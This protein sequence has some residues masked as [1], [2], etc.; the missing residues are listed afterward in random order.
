MAFVPQKS[1]S[2]NAFDML[3]KWLSETP[4]PAYFRQI[5][6]VANEYM[7]VC[8]VATSK[9][10]GAVMKIA[11]RMYLTS[12]VYHE[13][14]SMDT[15][16][17]EHR[18]QDRALQHID[19]LDDMDPVVTRVRHLV[20]MYQVEVEVLARLLNRHP[21]LR[22]EAAALRDAAEATFVEDVDT[23]SDEDEG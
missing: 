5:E 12:S 1:M 18:R 20:Q 23:S 13:R 6:H 16:H 7:Q 2:Q 19:R 9:Y 21:R 22:R 10:Q 14:Q 17:Q 11:T 4:A 15:L 8:S 3:M